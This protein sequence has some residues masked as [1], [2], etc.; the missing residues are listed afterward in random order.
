MKKLFSAIVLSAAVAFAS[1]ASAAVQEFGPSS[2]RFTVDVPAGWTAQPVEGGVQ[3]INPAKD[4][5][6]AV[7]VAKAEGADVKTLAEAI[8]KE[9]GYT[10]PSFEKED[11]TITIT[12][13]VNG[14]DVIT[15][16]SVEDGTMVVVTMAGKDLDGLAAVIDTL[17]EK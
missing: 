17:E 3:L 12:G 9:S 16:V 8:A 15:L 13:Q 1:V 11:D 14:A 6:A 7:M 2:N 4:S 10:N 5:S